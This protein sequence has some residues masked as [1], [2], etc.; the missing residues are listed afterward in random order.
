MIAGVPLWA[1][2]VLLAA[3]GGWALLLMGLTTATRPRPVKP[4]PAG[5]EL[6]AESPALVNLLTNGWRMTEDALAA[7]LL[8]LA[9][10]DMIDLVQQG[11][12]PERT[13]CVI[14]EPAAP[15]LTPYER[16]VYDRVAGL[17]AGGVVPVQALARGTRSQ[18]QKWW[19]G[20]RREVIVDAQAR[21]LSRNRFGAGVKTLFSF[22]SLFPAAAVGI[23]VFEA[24]DEGDGVWGASFLTWLLLTGYAASRDRQRDTPAG[25]EVAARWLGLREHLGR[26]EVFD[27]LPP[28]AVAI[29]D[30]YLGYGAA[31]GVAGSASRVLSFG[32]QSE[33]LAWS[34]YGGTW[35][36]V[37]IRYPGN[38]AAEGRHPVASA[39][40]G[41]VV[42]AAAWYALRGLRSLR[43][44]LDRGAGFGL[45]PDLDAR[46]DNGWTRL[47][48]LVLVA[49]AA[50]LLVWG[51]WTVV[52]A[53][54]DL[55]ART[56]F[57]AE[58]LRIRRL[59]GDEDEVKEYQVA[60]DD[61]KSEKTRAWSLPPRRMPPL[62][63]R[64]VV[65]VT[66]GRWLRHVS[67]ITV[68]RHGTVISL[69]DGPA[70]DSQVIT[71]PAA[72][73]ARVHRGRGRRRARPAGEPPRSRR[74]R[75]SACT[76]PSSPPS[77][78]RS[79]CSSR[80]PPAGSRRR[81]PAWPGA[82]VA[83]TS[84]SAT[85][86]PRSVRATRSRSCTSATP[87]RRPRGSRCSASPSWR[88]GA[89][90]RAGPARARRRRS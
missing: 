85:A 89:R 47:A 86:P 22:A 67:S 78:A 41:I 77:A 56:T 31:T 79:A 60:L 2:V 66:A 18:A 33:R 72:G 57:E 58:V 45:G 44:R 82:P 20:F 25:R 21:G 74:R 46:L 23:V 15:D 52:R 71:T 1:V 9:A 30:R 26:N 87:T 80:R 88:P 37:R 38:R 42:G 40:V 50:V 39:L 27:T 73:P 12:E 16:R 55:G 61:G 36:R 19:R 5:L 76:S 49:G 24:S 8:D 62:S 6:G 51:A 4:G 14:R 43:D 65:S 59:T 13:I 54:L 34:A 32:A 81:P 75:C 29:W 28:A 83:A 70:A 48:L 7:T 35:H 64:D 69:D 3:A 84:T 17:A 53:A 63:E 90:R 11:P 68:V 10:R